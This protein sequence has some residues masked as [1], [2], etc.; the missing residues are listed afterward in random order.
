MSLLSKYSLIA[1][2][3]VAGFSGAV[4]AEE[5]EAANK[6]KLELEKMH[7]DAKSAAGA[8][9]TDVF[10]CL[11]AHVQAEVGEDQDGVVLLIKGAAALLAVADFSYPASKHTFESLQF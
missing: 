5:N 10:K 9:A 1:A 11:G 8:A 7:K 3:A 2:F 4:I 6:S